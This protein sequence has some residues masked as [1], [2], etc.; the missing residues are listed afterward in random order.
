MNYCLC[1]MKKYLGSGKT[2][3]STPLTHRC[4]HSIVYRQKI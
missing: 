4:V 2:R 3:F 1:D